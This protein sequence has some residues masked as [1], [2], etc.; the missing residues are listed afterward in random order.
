MAVKGA[1][2][3]AFLAKEKLYRGKG[4]IKGL[5][6]DV[7]M[8][9]VSNQIACASSVNPKDDYESKISVAAQAMGKMAQKQVG[10]ANVE[11][12]AET[13]VEYQSSTGKTISGLVKYEAKCFTVMMDV[14]VEDTYPLKMA[15]I[16]LASNADIRDAA[17]ADFPVSALKD[18]ADCTED[19]DNFTREGVFKACDAFYFGL[20]AN[21]LSINPVFNSRGLKNK[22]ER[23]VDTKSFVWDW[24]SEFPKAMEE[25]KKAEENPEEE[26]TPDNDFTMPLADFFEKCKKGDFLI[27][28]HWPD[29]VKQYIVPLDFLDGFIPTECFRETLLSTYRQINEILDR[30][31]TYETDIEKKRKEKKDPNYTE[32]YPY[33]KIMGTDPINIK[34]MGKPGTGKTVMIE[35]ILAS[36][37]YPK[38]IIN[39]KGRME[40]DEIE[41]MNKFV[42]GVV[43]SIPTKAGELHS[44]GG[45]VLLEEI[46]L[47]DPDILQGAL[48]QAL[49]YP[50]ILKVNGYLETKRSPMTIY[51]ATMNIGTQG[52]KPLN[53][54]L[55]SRF[56]EGHI[57]EDVSEEEFISILTRSGN[58]ESSC[59]TVYNVYQEILNYL[60][61]YQEDLVRS[62]TMRHCL[63][64]LHQLELGFPLKKAVKNT[65]ISQIYSTDPEV[66]KT[67]EETIPELQ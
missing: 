53:E 17:A 24:R 38:G 5:P 14:S 16:A 54:A 48:G 39:C 12:L 65:F 55:S 6:F 10:V 41:G 22:V 46:N 27:H 62:V 45:A 66:A 31:K 42:N 63:T 64:C 60:R 49:V 51:F 57:L 8:G 59:R 25:Q 2:N 52:T 28:Y 58:K 29:S 43:A 50:Y 20:A 4:N 1:L 30:E 7:K 15:F 56:P 33:R 11:G 36:L 61:E 35:A 3:M 26:T 32:P 37:G 18:I 19:W 23:Y 9:E 13:L 34:V 21:G 67:L 47:P 40:E 44:Q